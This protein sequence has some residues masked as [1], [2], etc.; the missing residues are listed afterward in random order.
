MSTLG[1]IFA[2]TG[3]DELPHC[4]SG[5]TLYPAWMLWTAS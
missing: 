4:D 3:G 5:V 2:T 1:S